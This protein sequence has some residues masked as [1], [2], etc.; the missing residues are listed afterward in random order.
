MALVAPCRTDGDTVA[1]RRDQLILGHMPQV[2]LIARRIQE[3]LPQHISLDDLVST[4][5]LGLIA[6]IDHFD[7]RLNVKLKTY[8]EY[9]IRGAILDSLREMDWVPRQKRRK[10]RQIEAA[11]A[12]AEQR[13]QRT[14]TEEETAGELRVSIQQFRQWL[15]EVRGIGL[16]RLRHATGDEARNIVETLPDKD[17]NQP[18]QV[19][20]RRQLQ[21]LLQQMMTRIPQVEQMVLRMYYQEG[22]TLREIA[23]IAHVH[24]SRI[25]QLK[26]QAIL[27]LRTHMRKSWPT[28]RG[29]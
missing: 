17:E 8:A 16:E 19:V 15:A 5:V 2:R 27:R 7:P 10:A 1:G 20:E 22:K 14:P 23:E 6:A 11:V 24:E 26:T 21:T 25:S 3:R 28:P 4:G 18:S 9:K 29:L 13:L 12:A